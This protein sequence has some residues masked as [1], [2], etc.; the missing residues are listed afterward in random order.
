MNCIFDIHGHFYCSNYHFIIEHF[1]IL[2]D[3][4]RVCPPHFTEAYVAGN[5]QEY[6][7]IRCCPEL[8]TWDQ[9]LLKCVSEPF[10]S[11]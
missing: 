8:T 11:S 5:F 6:S 3:G 1:G 9:L 4:L 10:L 7:K 2:N